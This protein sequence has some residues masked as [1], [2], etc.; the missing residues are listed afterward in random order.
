MRFGYRSQ[1]HWRSSCPNDLP[2]PSSTALTCVSDF[3]VAVV[4]R[5]VGASHELVTDTT[6]EQLYDQG[7][8]TVYRVVRVDILLE[9]AL[10]TTK[11]CLLLGISGS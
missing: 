11:L 6:R 5:R 4:H 3:V 2:S 10:T 9:S 1:K 7:I 8:A